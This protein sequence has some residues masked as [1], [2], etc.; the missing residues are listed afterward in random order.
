MTIESI[1]LK[2]GQLYLAEQVSDALKPVSP[3]RNERVQVVKKMFGK[4][5]LQVGSRSY[6]IMCELDFIPEMVTLA[7]KW[8]SEYGENFVQATIVTLNHLFQ[9]FRQHK[10]VYVGTPFVVKEIAIISESGQTNQPFVR[11]H[12]GSVMLSL[13]ALG[14]FLDPAQKRAADDG[15]NGGGIRLYPS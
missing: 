6:P 12:V 4:C 14:V 2:Q 13:F 1:Y 8:E 9:F 11:V 7:R 3:A 5:E 10:S 15:L